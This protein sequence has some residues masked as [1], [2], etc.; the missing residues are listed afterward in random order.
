MSAPLKPGER[1]AAVTDPVIAD[2]YAR[3]DDLL[4]KAGGLEILDPARPQLRDEFFKTLL[5]LKPPDRKQPLDAGARVFR[6]R[7]ADAE[8]ELARLEA[9][10]ALGPALQPFDTWLQEL[11]DP[12]TRR[13]RRPEER[14]LLAPLREVAAALVKAD[15]LTREIGV[16]L[17]LDRLKRLG[18]PERRSRELLDAA[19]EAAV[20]QADAMELD[21]A[22]VERRLAEL[23]VAAAPVLAAPDPLVP[24]DEAI[25]RLYGGDRKVPMTVY[26]A[27]TGR[28]LAQR[29]GSMPCHT[30]VV[31]PSSAGKS[32]LLKATLRL[33]PTDAYADIDAGSARVVIYDARPVQHRAIV[34]A[35]QDSIPT[36]EDNPATSAVRHLLQENELRWQVV[37]RDA[38]TGEHYVRAVR[39]R[40]PS[41]LLTTGTRRFIEQRAEQMDTRVFTVEVAG[42]VTQ[43]RAALETMATIEA[44][45]LPE[46]DQ[47]LVAYQ[48][49]LQLLSPWEVVVPFADTLAKRLGET[50]ASPR[51]LRDYLKI[52]ALIK[53]VAVLRHAHRQRDERGRLVATLADYATVYDLV[54]GV[55]EGATSGATDLIRRAVEVVRAVTNARPG[56]ATVREVARALGL[57]EMTAWRHVRTALRQRWLVNLEERKYRPARLDVGDPVPEQVGLPPPEQLGGRGVENSDNR[58]NAITSDFSP[59]IPETCQLSFQLSPAPPTGDNWPAGGAAG[60]SGEAG[61]LVGAEAASSGTS[62]V[63][64]AA[65]RTPLVRRVP[66]AHQ[67]VEPMALDRGAPGPEPGGGR[68]LGAGGRILWNEPEVLAFWRFIVERHRLFLRRFV[69]RTPPPWTSDP[70]VATICTTNVYRELDRGTRYVIVQIL[71]H[72]SEAPADTLFNVLVYRTF[73]LIE[74]YE[75][76]G[77]FQPAAAWDPRRAN[78][79]LAQREQSNQKIFTAAYK[80]SPK[81]KG[82]PQGLTKAEGIV[83]RLSIIHQRLPELYTALTTAA[84]LADAHRVLT[85]LPGVAGFTAYEIASDLIHGKALL[86]FG[87]D[88]WVHVGPG[89]EDGLKLLLGLT[90]LPRDLATA[91]L[92]ELRWEQGEWLKRAGEVLQGPPLTLRN[93]EHA[94]CEYQKVTGG[95]RGERPKRRFDPARAN[96]DLSLWDT[97]PP[98]FVVPRRPPM[99]R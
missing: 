63:A 94:L 83:W 40:G 93:V 21:P 17:V 24:V 8:R 89:A 95:R 51:V 28:V 10:Q 13:A 52:L 41:V 92:H 90:G 78:E 85:R 97:I 6:Y 74:T 16:D 59:A 33:F 12:I 9:E 31:G 72:A 55:Y 34:F 84:S 15:R 3:V 66:V 4:K 30:L 36:D 54:K 70:V 22:E 23:R 25:G 7:L 45:G 64:R 65:V 86:P 26:L 14:E 11:E 68:Y 50:M 80:I 61:E 88:D 56:G 82:L 98:Q 58:D 38:E 60:L 18:L 76:L 32:Y 91:A 20:A 47:A 29:Q 5:P 27:T 43:I 42:D 79:R 99:T 19:M 87:E 44:R 73:N 35:E 49:Y 62:P 57:A 96:S 1:L 69:W 77:G 39:R 71:P 48:A 53:A 75:A 46:P 37:E 81:A 67:P 2:A